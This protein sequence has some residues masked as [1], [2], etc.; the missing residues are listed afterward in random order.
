MDM[1]RFFLYVIAIAALA[2]AGC[3]GNG[4]MPPMEMEME[5][6]DDE[7]VVAG[8]TDADKVAMA[9]AI[10]PAI[11]DPDGDGIITGTTE[12]GLLKTSRP[13]RGRDIFGVATGG[14][15]TVTTPGDDA[16]VLNKPEKDVE[17]EFM[18]QMDATRADLPGFDV[19][20]QERTVDKVTDTLTIY[21]NVDAP[22]NQAYSIYYQNNNEGMVSTTAGIAAI[23]DS[24]TNKRNVI[25]FE[26]DISTIEKYFEGSYF[27]AIGSQNFTYADDY[28]TSD[29]SQGPRKFSGSFHGIPGEFACQAAGPCTAAADEDGKLSMLSDGWTFVPSASGSELK[30]QD[31]I[32][33]SDFLSF[34]YWVRATEQRDGST[35][36]AIDTFADGGTPFT[37]TL[38]ALTGRATYSG[39]ATGMYVR[40]TFDSA[41]V[42]TPAASGQFSAN[43]DFTAEFDELANV[44]SVNQHAIRGMITSFMDTT[45]GDTIQGWELTMKG[46]SFDTATTG[47]A[48]YE[49]DT[50]GGGADGE[51]TVSFFGDP[52]TN[53]PLTTDVDETLT[54]Y[55]TGVAGEFNGHFVDGHAVGAFG[56]TR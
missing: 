22:T 55:P 54:G 3:G 16:D 33:D 38:T 51:W 50:N 40:K 15:T 39:S 4:G 11:A 28:Q 31:V 13:G 43:A 17:N 47:N 25:T 12:T 52:V 35:K 45:S 29:A 9:K 27:P 44:A 36:Y 41:G 7:M 42:G 32:L 46:A 53:D 23:A 49:G 18:M 26:A 48:G 56:A 19:S 14:V 34:G 5:D 10:A 1:K 6:D 37:P 2:L 20:V 24:S 30:V 21:H 8:P